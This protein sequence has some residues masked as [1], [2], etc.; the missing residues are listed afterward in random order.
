VATLPRSF[1]ARSTP[2]VA[3]ELVG[4]VLVK[5]SADGLSSGRI[6]ETEA[7]RGRSDPAS[8]A[9][10]G[11]TRRNEVMF[12][13]PG[14]LYVYLSYGVHY[15]CNVVT[16]SDGVAGAV[17]LR[18]LEPLAGIELMEVRRGLSP[19]R[20]LCNGPGKLCQALEIGGA[21]Y[22]ADLET[23]T[24]WLEDDG[25]RPDSLQV[26]A[27]VGISSAAELPLRFFLQGN[28]FV[29]PGKPST[30]SVTSIAA[31]TSIDQT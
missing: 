3:R 4:K 25:Y 10:R 6:V 23:S 22:G 9:Y 5:E 21:D 16:E 11:P 19:P 28:P 2:L 12:G 1:Y 26:S 27:R 30:P 7:Y 15:C 29:S 14:Y 20:R 31:R 8:H 18:A 13:P 17:L 24:I